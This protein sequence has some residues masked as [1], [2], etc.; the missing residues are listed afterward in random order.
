MAEKEDFPK[1]LGSIR[2]GSVWCWEPLKPDISVMVSVLKTELK[3]DGN[4]WVETQCIRSRGDATYLQKN[5][6]EIS[7]FV[8]AA[9]LVSPAE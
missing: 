4:W 2:E 9:V 6:N 3:K 1:A 7:R 5:W 8:E